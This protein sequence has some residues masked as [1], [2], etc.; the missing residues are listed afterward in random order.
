MRNEV[1]PRIDGRLPYVYT[2]LYEGGEHRP[3]VFLTGET[4]TVRS[5]RR[6]VGCAKSWAPG[7]LLIQACAPWVL[8]SLGWSGSAAT[9]GARASMI[10]PVARRLPRSCAIAL[11]PKI[12]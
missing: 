5:C 6:Y 10:V 12:M 11:L 9:V 7:P 1:A 2:P 8:G 4:P 3:G